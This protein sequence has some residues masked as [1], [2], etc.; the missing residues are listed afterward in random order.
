MRLASLFQDGAVLQRGRVIPV[1]GRTAPEVMVSGELNGSRV[2]TRSSRTGDFMLFFPA[3]EPGGPYRL[4]VAAP[5]A[6]ER[7]AVANVLIGEVWLASGQSNMEYQL[8]ADW[9]TGVIPDEG[10]PVCRRQEKEFNAEVAAPEL[11]RYFS[12]ARRAT[13]APEVTAEGRWRPMTAEDSGDCSAV[14]AWFGLYLRKKLDVPVG[15]IVSAWGGT[16]AEAWTSLA[17]LSADP[18]TARAA[19][20]VFSSQRNREAYAT[21]AGKEMDLSRCPGVLPDDGNAGFGKGWAKPDFDDSGWGTMDVPGSWVKQGVAGNGAVWIRKQLELPA[22]WVGC[23]LA[24]R[25]GGIDKH[26]VSYFNGVEIGRTGSGLETA[27]WNQARNYAIPAELVTS[28]RATVAVRGFSFSHDGSFMG[29]W[30]LVRVADG[31]ALRLNGAWR[32]AVEYDRGI[33]NVRKSEAF[34]GS[35][36]PNTPGILFDGMIRPLLPAAVRGVIWYQGES[37]AANCD[38]YYAILKRMIADWR[39]GLMDPELPFIQVQLAG[40]AMY[41]PFTVDADWAVIRETQR[42]LAAEDA[43]TFMASAMDRGEELDI[44]PQDKK[45]VGF[46]LAQCALH[47]VY[48]DKATVPGGPEVREAVALPDGAVRIAFRYADGMELRPGRGQSFYL[49]ADGGT[50]VPADA[51]AVAGD[52]V[53]VRS[54]ALPTVSEVRYAWSHFPAATLYNGAGLPASP[55]RLRVAK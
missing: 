38:E 34:F 10:E 15:L 45:T 23:E 7:V 43:H 35:G 41:K 8:N 30:R 25:T 2:Y 20:G 28:R 46:R 32:T 51:V 31:A 22:D 6:E 54:A 13:G 40:Y 24:L 17:G 1:W 48:G 12:V 42:Q 55:F 11:F 52:T 50:F 44:H 16:V 47:H 18:A 27:Y 19:A 26:D 3:Q 39:Y 4:E 49:S 33:V 36:N 53:T 37:N 9:R 5:E 29:D 14:A 21:A